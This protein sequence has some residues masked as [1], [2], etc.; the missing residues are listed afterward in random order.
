MFQRRHMNE[1]A[2]VLSETGAGHVVIEAFAV[3]LADSN[4]NFN[5][6]RFT[7]ACGYP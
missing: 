2:K 6:V 1:I 7:E 3:M 4:P 5:Y